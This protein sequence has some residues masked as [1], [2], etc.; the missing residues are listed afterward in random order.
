MDTSLS[1]PGLLAPTLSNPPV[2]QQPLLWQHEGVQCCLMAL[3]PHAA[4]FA[5]LYGVW[6]PLRASVISIAGFCSPVYQ[7]SA[8]EMTVQNAKDISVRLPSMMW[9]AQV[10]GF[11]RH[12]SRVTLRHAVSRL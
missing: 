9:D 10:G 11:K 6:S 8:D 3:K 2:L 4:K 12:V 5:S 1:F 7:S